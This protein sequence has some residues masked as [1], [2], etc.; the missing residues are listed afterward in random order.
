MSPPVECLADSH[1]TPDARIHTQII[2]FASA[3]TRTDGER[4]VRRGE[5]QMSRLQ[6][7]QSARHNILWS[8]TITP[9]PCRRSTQTN[10]MRFS[11]VSAGTH[12]GRP[13]TPEHETRSN[14]CL[15]HNGGHWSQRAGAWISYSNPPPYPGL[16]SAQA[17]RRKTMVDARP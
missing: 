4:T 1:R 12:L 14:F 16:S 17:D 15:L 9:P 8:P 11:I 13:A 3:Y 2:V 10:H 5:V 6:L 7:V